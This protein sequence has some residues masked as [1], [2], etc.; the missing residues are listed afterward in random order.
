MAITLHHKWFESLV[1]PWLD[2]HN[3]GPWS[4][5]SQHCHMTSSSSTNCLLN[6]RS[7]TTRLHLQYIAMAWRIRAT[8]LQWS[9]DQAVLSTSHTLTHFHKE[10]K[11]SKS[12][13]NLPSKHTLEITVLKLT[14]QVLH[15]HQTIPAVELLSI[16]LPA[17]EPS[18]LSLASCPLREILTIR[19]WYSL[20]TRSWNHLMSTSWALSLLLF[21]RTPFIKWGNRDLRHHLQPH[22]LFMVK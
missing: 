8:T 6:Y 19:L 13:S 2:C 21:K 12:L 5:Q 16:Y 22:R 14:W 20:A 11:D 3:L 4:T 7:T 17:K 9:P 18:D 1:L 15:P 10:T